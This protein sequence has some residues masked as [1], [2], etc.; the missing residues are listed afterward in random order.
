MC[1][2]H[3]SID[4]F[5]FPSFCHTFWMQFVNDGKSMQLMNE[6]RCKKKNVTE[7]ELN[8]YECDVSPPIDS[9]QMQWDNNNHEK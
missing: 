9:S 7:S 4:W 1:L 2:F 6:Q 5:N 8:W 3:N